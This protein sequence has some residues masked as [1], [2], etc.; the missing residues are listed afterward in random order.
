[1]KSI[2]IVI[3]GAALAAIGATVI[4]EF[5]GMNYSGTIGC[6]V[7]GTVGYAISYACARKDSKSDD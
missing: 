6:A 3:L 2:Y 7:G 4:V 5:L 1:V